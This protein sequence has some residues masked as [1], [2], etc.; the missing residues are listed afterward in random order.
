M[1]RHAFGLL[2]VSYSA[3]RRAAQRRHCTVFAGSFTLDEVLEF[4]P[5]E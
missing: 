1:F 2:P 3:R 5:A 4:A